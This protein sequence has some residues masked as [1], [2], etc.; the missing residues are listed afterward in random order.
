MY[1]GLILQTFRCVYITGTQALSAAYNKAA[2]LRA[3]QAKQDCS[4]AWQLPCF[5][6]KSEVARHA[7]ADL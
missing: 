3:S 7:E 5:A 1:R 6:W 2:G 4:Q